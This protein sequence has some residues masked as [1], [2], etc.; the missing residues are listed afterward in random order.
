VRLQ[1]HRHLRGLLHE[2]TTSRLRM[3]GAR[4]S[5]HAALSAQAQSRLMAGR[6]ASWTGPA[7]TCTQLSQICAPS[8][9]HL[10]RG[11]EVS[12][13]VRSS[14]LRAVILGILASWCFCRSVLASQSSHG[15]PL[16]CTKTRIRVLA[17][18]RQGIGGSSAW[19]DVACCLLQTAGW[20]ISHP[21]MLRSG[22]CD[23]GETVLET[24]G[25]S[26]GHS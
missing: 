19:R 6:I 15:S 2:H 25:H 7:W 17:G 24:L 16:Q 11:C 4:S 21:W 18:L 12:E 14:S 10:R 1:R 26:A 23:A 5:A 20:H 13:G 22:C 8:R 3:S 9:C